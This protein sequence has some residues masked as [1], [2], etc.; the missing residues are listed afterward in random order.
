MNDK[1]N[2]D[3]WFEDQKVLADKVIETQ[4]ALKDQMDTLARFNICTKDELAILIRSGQTTGDPLTDEAILLFGLDK[5]KIDRILAFDKSLVEGKEILIAVHRRVCTKHVMFDTPTCHNEY[6][7]MTGYIYGTLSGEKLVMKRTSEE[8][9]SKPDV[10]LP[11]T[12]YVKWDFERN[13]IVLP[14]VGP[15]VLSGSRWGAFRDLGWDT[16]LLAINPPTT[17]LTEGDFI[18]PASQVII[19]GNIP[20]KEGSD[21]HYKLSGALEHGRRLIQLANPEEKL[22]GADI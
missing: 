16:L 10:V 12:R 13:N 3:Q 11:L 15:L 4:K 6:A 20:G 21:E 22:A 14:A 5:A 1:I 9:Q 17:M 2:L 8:P 19:D 18:P 7:T